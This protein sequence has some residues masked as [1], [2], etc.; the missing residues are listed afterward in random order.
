LKRQRGFQAIWVQF[1]GHN[2]RGAGGGRGKGRLRSF[3]AYKS[4]NSA[5]HTIAQS[6]MFV[7]L[8]FTDHFWLFGAMYTG[9][10]TGG[11]GFAEG[12][13]RRCW[14]TTREC[15]AGVLRVPR[16]A[17]EVPE[18]LISWVPIEPPV[19]SL[20]ECREVFAIRSASEGTGGTTLQNSGLNMK[21]EPKAAAVRTFPLWRSRR[22]A[23]KK[24][25]GSAGGGVCRRR[26]S[27]LKFA[28]FLY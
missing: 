26:P 4:W 24:D 28:A 7:K 12:S 25:T 5:S 2:R 11:A 13:S 16:R 22:V 27:A 14:P 9:A 17:G 3:Y 8:N 21:T 1:D 19:Q 18:F 15:I 10:Q 20:A 6:Y 23:L